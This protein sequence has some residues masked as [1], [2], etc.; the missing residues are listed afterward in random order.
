MNHLFKTFSVFIICFLLFLQ[1]SV[2]QDIT[3]DTV[4]AN[5]YIEKAKILAKVRNFDSSTIYYIK[6]SQLFYKYFQ[7]TKELSHS[8]TALVYRYVDC[9]NQVGIDLQ[10]LQLYDSSISILKQ[11]IQTSIFFVGKNN[12]LV[13]RSFNIVGNDYKIKCILDSAFVYHKI[14]LQIRISLFGEKHTDVANS[15]NNIGN[16]YTDKNEYDMALE[17]HYQ[18]LQIRLELQGENKVVVADAYNN[19]GFIY[20]NK[21]EY[22][23]ALDYYSKALKIYSELLGADS[24]EVALCIENI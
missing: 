22:N 6:A 12:K 23:K 17:Y 9:Q 3:A 15:Y 19:I 8:D 21:C 4:I 24:R 2:A 5:N 11:A 14:A 18:A 1:Y 7:S 16:D 13:A 20:R 10:T